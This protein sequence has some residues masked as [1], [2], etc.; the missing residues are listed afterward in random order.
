MTA[1]SPLPVLA[2]KALDAAT[3]AGWLGLE[4]SRR[5]RHKYAC[6]W[7]ESSDALHLYL[8][9]GRGAHCFACAKSY[10][11]IDLVM[12]V[13]GFAFREAL[14]WLADRAGILIPDSSVPDS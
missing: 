3:V 6:R 12:Q 11:V 14:T 1:T 9:P 7:C 4:P 5:E 13:R 8:E 2:V 10:S